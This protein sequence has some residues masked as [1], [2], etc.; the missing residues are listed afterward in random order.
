MINI[1]HISNPSV[2]NDKCL[3]LNNHLKT[4]KY[5][6]GATF[7]LGAF[8]VAQVNSFHSFFRKNS[9]KIIKILIADY[10]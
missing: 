7:T 9:H 1:D 6:G 8:L 2:I 5:T 4:L 3:L 10:Y